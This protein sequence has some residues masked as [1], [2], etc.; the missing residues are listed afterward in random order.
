MQSDNRSPSV[1]CQIDADRA[2]RGGLVDVTPQSRSRTILAMI[3]ELGGRSIS[4]FTTADWRE[5][6]PTVA[7]SK[8]GGR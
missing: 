1:L 3:E 8:R 2:V 4:R 5:A 6:C 7:S